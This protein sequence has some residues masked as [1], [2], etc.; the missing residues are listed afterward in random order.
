[1]I[2]SSS[3]LE[4]IA[5]SPL[6][7]LLADIEQSSEQPA[8]ESSHSVFLHPVKLERVYLVCTVSI[9]KM[10]PSGHSNVHSVNSVLRNI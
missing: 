6:S 7:I 8:K 9:S 3:C 5:D 1:M 10:Q 4:E 2:L